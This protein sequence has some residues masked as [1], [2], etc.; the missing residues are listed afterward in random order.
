[1]FQA[2]IDEEGYLTSTAVSNVMQAGAVQV[3]EEFWPLLDGRANRL[4]LCNLKLED[5]VL[6][7][8]DIEELPE[9]ELPAPV[10]TWDN[11]S[12]FKEEFSQQERIA[13]RQ[14]A[15]KDPIAEDWLDM[16]N[17]YTYIAADD[18]RLLQGLGYM[19][20]QGLLTQDRVNQILAL[21]QGG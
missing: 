7:G 1:M 5:E 18:Q 14:Y 21:D 3:S 2:I 12:A 16:L 4:K 8:A 20:V 11:P 13:M 19:V 6:I 9:P 10:K 15:K 17:G